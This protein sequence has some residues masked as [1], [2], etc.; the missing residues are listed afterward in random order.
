[1]FSN[2]LWRNM[3]KISHYKNHLEC[4]IRGIVVVLTNKYPL[5][6]V[7]R[8]FPDIPRETKSTWGNL[9]LGRN[10]NK[11]YFLVSIFFGQAHTGNKLYF[12]CCLRKP[13]KYTGFLSEDR[14]YT[15]ILVKNAHKF[16]PGTTQNP[17]Q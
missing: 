3:Y 13:P 11:I 17:Y 5:C 6:Y 12:K 8:A 15:S 14:I 1:M 4:I 16:S 9:I 7:S 10:A 2:L